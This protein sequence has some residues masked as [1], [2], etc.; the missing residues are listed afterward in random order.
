MYNVLFLGTVC[1]TPFFIR[2]K[3]VSNGDGDRNGTEQLTSK[4][5]I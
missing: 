2:S 1:S 5:L 3:N 4:D